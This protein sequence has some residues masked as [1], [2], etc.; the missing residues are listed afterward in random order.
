M[1]IG[2][3][4]DFDACVSAQ[5]RKGKSDESAKKICGAI[6]QRAKGEEFHRAGCPCG[7]CVEVKF[8]ENIKNGT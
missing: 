6:E 7:I 5:K 4:K 3:Y 2:P 8:L 1:P